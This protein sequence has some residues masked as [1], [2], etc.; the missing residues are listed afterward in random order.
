MLRARGHAEQ[1]IGKSSL[2]ADG[3]GL[4]LSQGN[5]ATAALS[6]IP[7]YGMAEVNTMPRVELGS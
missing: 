2:G 6:G 7:S 4:L 1:D 5:E 3:F